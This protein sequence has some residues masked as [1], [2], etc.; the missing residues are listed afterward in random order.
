M[1]LWLAAL[2]F[3]LNGCALTFGYR[4]AD[5]MIR[6]QLD[7]YLDLTSGQ[8]RDVTARLKPLL[9]RHRKEALPQYEQFLKNLQ[10]RVSRGLTQEDL[11]WMYRS[12][13]RFRADLFERLVPDSSAL[14]MSVSE[15]QVRYLEKVF[16]KEESKAA[17]KLQEPI[18]TRLEERTK[19]ILARAEDWL[20]PLS[21]EQVA[22]IRPLAL[23]I[24]DT[25]PVWRDYRRQRQ[26]ELL[27]LL[28]EPLPA[29]VMSLNL[30]QMFVD[31]D[32]TAPAKYREMEREWRLSVET[33]VLETDRILTV[34]QRRRAMT[35]LQT[36]IDDLRALIH[37]S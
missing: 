24:P 19:K 10:E 22:R 4:H 13:D 12:Y 3:L 29:D 30:R 9:S 14:L 17:S 7:H 27:M 25:Q 21:S 5:W 6:W 8:R 36:V 20:G 34:Q 18:S 33:L 2:L 31:S 35:S 26:E 1:A 37:G 11:E 16:H 23:S 28:R 32:Q 15:K